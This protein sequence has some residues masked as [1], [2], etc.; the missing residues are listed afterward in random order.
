MARRGTIQ[1]SAELAK[2]RFRQPM[3]NAAQVTG[4]EDTERESSCVL[5][6]T[7][8]PPNPRHWSEAAPDGSRLCGSDPRISE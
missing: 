1:R 2:T 6:G 3:W 7:A 8:L 5:C 4:R